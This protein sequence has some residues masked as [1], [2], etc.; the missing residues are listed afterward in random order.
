MQRTINANN[1]M[2]MFIGMYGFDMRKLMT[3][4]KG[5]ILNYLSIVFSFFNFY[6]LLHIRLLS[7]ICFS[8]GCVCVCAIFVLLLNIITIAF[9]F[10]TYPLQF[11]I[12]RAKRRVQEERNESNERTN[13]RKNNVLHLLRS[14]PQSLYFNLC[15]YLIQ[16]PI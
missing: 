8:L 12:Y 3:Y 13:E 5:I 4:T 7:A 1:H 9:G 2:D 14:M 16:L 11:L 10:S 15:M 6:V